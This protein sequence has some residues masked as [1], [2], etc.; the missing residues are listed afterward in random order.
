MNLNAIGKSLQLYYADNNGAF[1]AV[2]AKGN[3]TSADG[4]LGLGSPDT[5]QNVY[6]LAGTFPP[7][8]LSL[9]VYKG[10]IP[11]DVFRC[12]ATETRLKDR[13]A[14]EDAYGFGDGRSKA[15]TGKNF[16]DYGLQ[17]PQHYM[18]PNGTREHKAYLCKSA[19][20]KL[21]IMADRP[22]D[23]F[24]GAWSPNHLSPKGENVLFF[25]GNVQM[26]LE[27]DAIKRMFR[28]GDPKNML[29]YKGNNI[30][31]LDMDADMVDPKGTPVPGEVRIGD[32]TPP[33]PTLSRWDSVIYWAPNPPATASATAKGKG[34]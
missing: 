3:D 28:G 7:D 30:Y 5:N 25:G 29:G 21:A 16:M 27:E 4:G 26:V 15:N 2:N 13:S 6:N 1:P 9:L 14:P 8:N 19:E 23:D 20:S 32:R 18:G 33:G 17:I 31:A 10:L 12:P 34:E 24:V 11:W 22:P